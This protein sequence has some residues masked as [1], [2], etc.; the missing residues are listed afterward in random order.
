MKGLKRNKH[1]YLIF[2]IQL[3]NISL[4]LHTILTKI[5]FKKMRTGNKRKQVMVSNKKTPKAVVLLQWLLLRLGMLAK[6]FS[7]HF[8]IFFS[9]KNK[10]EI[11]LDI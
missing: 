5:Y 6:N 7:R 1:S 2:F 11:R 9:K 10:V 3:N 4:V 8:E